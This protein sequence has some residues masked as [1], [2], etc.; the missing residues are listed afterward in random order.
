MVELHLRMCARR[1]TRGPQAHARWRAKKRPPGLT[2]VFAGQDAEA[3]ARARDT[4]HLSA[5]VAQ[6]AL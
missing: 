4:S 6:I 3:T 5:V 1:A 2:T